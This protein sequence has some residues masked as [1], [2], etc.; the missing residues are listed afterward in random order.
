MPNLYLEYFER[1]S[2]KK[3]L[4]SFFVLLLF[5][6]GLVTPARAQ[7]NV[8]VVSDAASLAFP[9]TIDFKAEFQSGA[10][11]TSVVLEYGSSQLT[12]GTVEAKAFPSVTPGT[13]V[14]VDW[15]WDMHQSGSLPPGASVW[16]QWLVTDSNGALFT[17]PKKTILWLDNTYSWQII[18]GGNI[19]LHYYAG[20]ASFAQQLHDAASAA[21]TRLSQDVGVTSDSPVDIYIFASSSDLQA[22]ILYAPSWAGGQAF[23][24]SNIVIIGIPPDQL[25]WGKSTEAHELTHVLVGHLTFSCLG[26]I[27]QWL[28]EGLAMYGEGGVQSAEQA[29]FDLAVAADTLPTLRSLTGGFSEES[30]RA[31]LSY[32]EA[33]SVVNFMIKTYGRSKMTTLLLDLRDGQTADQALQA[34]YAFNVDGLDAAWRISIGAR[35][36][37]AS[38]QATP[39]PT[40][41]EVPTFIPVGVAPQAQAI[42]T[43]AAALTPTQGQASA[44]PVATLQAATPT[45]G[46]LPSL[47]LPGARSN[48][49]TLIMIAV[50]CLVLL[51]VMAG[52]AIFL[53]VRNQNKRS[54]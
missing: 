46:A 15:T 3:S 18:S 38:S 52:L 10:Q 11:I 7:V 23:P 44:N 14:K 17:S 35:S 41:T 1:G 20:G 47:Q 2:M 4:S 27:P 53:I 28:N 54:K 32:T 49:T 40:P 43:P 9:N 24:E 33:Y 30:T 12:C 45:A 29:Q 36:H 16:W 42:S 13:S 51:M 37:S 8:Q 31:T 19:N 26:F 39:L 5:L 50:A 22:S 6:A 48:I 21:L 25:D 34:V